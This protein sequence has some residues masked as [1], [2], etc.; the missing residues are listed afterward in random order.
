MLNFKYRGAVLFQEFSN[1]FFVEA[2]A[3]VWLVAHRHIYPRLFVENAFVMRERVEAGFT[4]VRAHAALAHA[5]EAEF[6]CCEVYDGVVHTAAAV[7][8]AFGNRAD[9]LAVFGKNIEREGLLLRRE[10]AENF[11]EVPVSEHG[12]HG[13]ED[14]FLH[15][16]VVPRHVV[17]HGR[18]DF[19]RL[20]VRPAARRDLRGVYES[21]NAGEMLFVDYLA[22]VG[23]CERVV[24]ELRLYL[25]GYRAHKLVFYGAV[26]KDIIGRD[27][28]LAAVEEFAEHDS[29]RGKADLSGRIHYARALPAQFEH[30]R[31]QVFRGVAEHFS[32]HVLAA[33]EKDHIEFFV[34]QRGVFL[35]AARD[36]RD[37]FGREALG[38]DFIDDRARRRRIGARLDYDRVARG[39]SVGDR[40]EREQQR[41]VPR[42]HDEDVAVRRRLD[43]TLRGELRHGRRN[44][45]VGGELLRMFYHIR[46]LG[47]DKAGFA[48]IAFVRAFAEIGGKGVGNLALVL[49]DCGVQFFQCGDTVFYGQRRAARKIRALAFDYFVYFSDS[50]D[51]SS[52][53]A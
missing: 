40:V 51:R 34:Q 46:K 52:D 44:A 41:I 27:A 7:T 38:Y 19:Q 23:V 13:A 45:A 15:D 18:L 5:A 21:G 35:S 26:A 49:R 22:V 25:R 33:G 48:H 4:V 39:D 32:A 3:L 28:G 2:A 36:N 47:E 11:A 20:R 50:H 53:T 6:A 10:Q 43:I 30:R 9:V 8:A 16:R 29:F 12:Q 37:V 31:G 17:Q 42:A 1:H 24:A 14:L